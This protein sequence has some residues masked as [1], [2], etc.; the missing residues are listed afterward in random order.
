MSTKRITGIALFTA[1]ALILSL[2]ES[3]LPPLFPYAPG[4]K[5]GLSNLATLIALVIL[6]YGD[7]FI[8]AALK[9]LLSSVFGG[10]LSALIYSV[11]S[12]FIS[13]AVM[14]LLY[15]FLWKWLSITGISFVGATVFNAVQLAVASMVAGVNLAPMLAFMLAASTLAG[16]GI[17]LIAFYLIKYLPLKLLYKQGEHNGI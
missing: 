11:P 12:A 5:L 15:R 6:G 10:N 1:V 7:A 3:V 16:V 13:L 2:I 17:G 8:V 9:C 4:V 14:S